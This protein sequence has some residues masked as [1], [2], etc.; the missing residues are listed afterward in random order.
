MLELIWATLTP[1]TMRNKSGI[2]FAADSGGVRGFRIHY[3]LLTPGSGKTLDE[4]LPGGVVLFNQNQSVFW[5]EPDLSDA[6]IFVTADAF[7]GP[8]EAHYGQHRYEISA[9]VWL[10]PVDQ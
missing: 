2:L 9:H 5:S 8:G 1:G 10:D 6:K 7:G 4:L 3:A